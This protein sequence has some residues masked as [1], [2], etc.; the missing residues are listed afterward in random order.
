MIQGELIRLK[1]G[2]Y[3]GRT[4]SWPADRHRLLTL[5]EHRQR[6]ETI[7][8]HYSAAVALQLPVFRP[9]WPIVHLTRIVPGPAQNRIGLVIHKQV[10][11]IVKPTAAL[12][13]AQTALLC[14]TSGLMAFDAALRRGLV[15]AD[16]LAAVAE[17]LHAH[18]GFQNL[19]VVQR[20]GDRRRESP[21]E[22]RTALTFDRLGFE[23]EPQFVVPGTS[24]RADGRISGTDVLVESD[25]EGKYE[26]QSD[27]MA[28][29]VREDDI[30][31][32]GFE[33][34]RV[35]DELLDRP[36]LLYARI[37]AALQRAR[38]RGLR[39]AS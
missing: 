38:E 29:K 27:V 22:S 7:P 15:T 16:D 20:L 3:T 28:E 10:G 23:L 5:I 32:L 36:R 1:R 37:Q 18:A 8:S 12:A 17:L 9:Q 13:V 33:M 19:A 21:L 39:A 35:T 30:R 24:F 25:G 6:P 31:T 34:L 14:P 11:E 2:W 4:L 26:D